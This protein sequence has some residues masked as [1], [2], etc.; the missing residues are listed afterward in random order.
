MLAWYTHWA[1]WEGLAMY[2]ALAWRGCV[3]VEYLARMCGLYLRVSTPCNI[4]TNTLKVNVLHFGLYSLKRLVNTVLAL[5]LRF[6]L[7][8][9]ILKLEMWPTVSGGKPRRKPS[10]MLNTWST[11]HPLA[12]LLP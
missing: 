12:D 2:G 1:T 5:L 8:G 4:L 11:C 6:S 10:A 9:I 7:Y 3:G